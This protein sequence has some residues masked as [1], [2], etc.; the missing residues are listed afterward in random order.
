[1]KSCNL[2][3]MRFCLLILRQIN[4]LS[5]LYK[6]VKIPCQNTYLFT[7][8]NRRNPEIQL[9]SS[10][11]EKE[12][13]SVKD[14]R[15]C[16]QTQ[17]YSKWQMRFCRNR[18]QCKLLFFGKSRHEKIAVSVMSGTGASTGLVL[19]GL[20]LAKYSYHVGLNIK[21]Y[22]FPRLR[23]THKARPGKNDVKTIVF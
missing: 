8:Y 11:L 14:S 17:L 7:L 9:R 19:T 20:R 23:P 6:I 5:Y 18:I 2:Y 4:F 21:Q 16:L 12:I 1:M 15:N 22:L 10:V 3:S 13:I